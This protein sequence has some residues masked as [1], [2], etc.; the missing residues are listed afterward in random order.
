MYRTRRRGYRP[1]LVLGLRACLSKNVPVL[2]RLEIVRRDDQGVR[3]LVVGE[4]NGDR[5]G[6]ATL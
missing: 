4:A 1:R 3:D 5:A 6:K 2:R